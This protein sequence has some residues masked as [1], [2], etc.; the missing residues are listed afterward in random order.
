MTNL[1]VRFAPSPTG[2]LHVGGG[3]TAHFN[4]FYARHLG[5]III[6]RIED[7]GVERF[8]KEPVDDFLQ[9]MELLG[10]NWDEEPF[11]Q[12]DNSPLYKEYVQKLLDSGKA[13]KCYCTSD[14]L[15]AKRNMAMKEGCKP[16]YGGTCR[17]RSNQPEGAP[18]GGMKESGIGREGSKYGIEELIEVKYLCMGGA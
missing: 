8:S 13:C 14:E 15:E 6:L 3:R 1:R 2:S 17:D 7:T 9:D 4:W 18:F 16:K 5:D 11:F 10:L 12:S